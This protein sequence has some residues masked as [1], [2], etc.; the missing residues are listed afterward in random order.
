MLEKGGDYILFDGDCGICSYLAELAGR[1]RGRKEFTIL[2]YQIIA[3]SE[4][5]SYGIGYDD[6]S[7][8]LQA[9]T[10]QGRVH[11]GALGVNYFLWHRFPWAILVLIIYL[12]P[13]LLVFEII[14]Y[15][16]IAANRHRIS[17]WLGLKS[18]LMK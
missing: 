1:M 11:S 9:I 12:V 18:C 8:A 17:G 3:E 6:C 2:P 16:L 14:G 10:R 4:L 7:R 5:A 13:V 15:R